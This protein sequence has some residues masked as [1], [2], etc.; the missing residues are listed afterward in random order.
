MEALKRVILGLMVL[1]LSSCGAAHKFNLAES[2]PPAPAGETPVFVSGT[3]SIAGGG[4]LDLAT[5]EGVPLVLI[6]SADSPTFKLH[7]GGVPDRYRADRIVWD[8]FDADLTRQ[9]SGLAACINVNAFS[10]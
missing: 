4:E 1:A 3:L 9:H 2:R 8:G 6:D 10:T 7:R 5:L